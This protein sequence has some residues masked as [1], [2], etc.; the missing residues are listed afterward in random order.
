MAGLRRLAGLALALAVVLGLGGC[1]YY[2]PV[3]YYPQPTAAAS[4]ANDEI[5][6]EPL[7][8]PPNCREFTQTITVGGQAVQA[9]GTA[10]R[11]PDGSWRIM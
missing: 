8:P 4:T 2:Y 3:P 6:S 10:C 5:R 7:P 9:T 11:Q 1:A